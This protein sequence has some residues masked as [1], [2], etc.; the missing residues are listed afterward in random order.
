MQCGAFLESNSLIILP[1]YM[2][3]S[4]F[5]LLVTPFYRPKCDVILFKTS[6]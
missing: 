5:S 6:V 2:V 4:E 3:L 1:F